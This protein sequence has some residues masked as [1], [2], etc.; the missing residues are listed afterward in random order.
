M[1]IIR[2]RFRIGGVPENAIELIMAGT[3]AATHSYYQA[4]WNVWSSW[5]SGFN[6]DPL[7]NINV[8]LAFLSD[9]FQRGKAYRTINVYRSMLSS[10]LQR[11]DG[12]AVGQH[13]LTISLMAGVFNSNPTR[14]RYEETW[15]VDLVLAH[16]RTLPNDGL[17]L[18]NLVRKL[19]C[20]LAFSSLLRVSELASISLD[21]V[22]VSEQSLSFSLLKPRKSQRSGPL[23]RILFPRF[24][25]QELDPVACTMAYIE[26]TR[27]LRSIINNSNLFVACV[28]PHK[29]VVGS[30]VAGWIKKQL[31]EAGVDIVIRF[32]AHSTRGAAA[33]KAAKA[34]I[35]IQA[36]LS[37]ASWEKESTFAAFYRRDV[38]AQSSTTVAEAVLS[39]E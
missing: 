18:T 34:G 12:V 22:V 25:N 13:P 20:L 3:R 24:E 32:S 21:T 33:S 7:C 15:D 8:I 1:E 19:V 4:A 30:T 10:T 14:P 37:S 39:T 38:S 26:K 36:I 23:H 17:S 9:C 35:P 11:V 28:K 31:G 5:C 29:P 2:N 27:P 16:L 6:H